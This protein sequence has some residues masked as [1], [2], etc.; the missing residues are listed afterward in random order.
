[1]KP[2]T[3]GQKEEFSMENS[4]ENSETFW[5]KPDVFFGKDG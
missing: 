2:P 1:L 5:K 4:M 3:S